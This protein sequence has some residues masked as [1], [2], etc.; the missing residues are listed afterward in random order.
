ML[1]AATAFLLLSGMVWY[2]FSKSEPKASQVSTKG[3]TIELSGQ[4]ETKSIALGPDDAEPKPGLAVS[5]TGTGQLELP[6]A[7]ST[8][9]QGGKP[10]DLSEFDQYKTHENV[11]YKDLILG[12]T[13]VAEAGKVIEVAYRGWLTDGQLFDEAKKIQPFQFTLGE[14][15]VITGFE[16]GVVGMSVGG[17]RLVVIPPTSG[18]GSEKKGSIPANSVLV[19]EIDLLSVK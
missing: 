10:I 8:N 9:D 13:A 18:Y 19:F 4:D 14:G 16:S 6:D 5:K 11:L 1:A 2:R 7:T 12:D 17:R 15:R 3:G